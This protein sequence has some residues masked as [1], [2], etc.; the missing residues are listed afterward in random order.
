MKKILA[1]LL[2]LCLALGFSAC[3]GSEPDGWY[4]EGEITITKK[5]AQ[6]IINGEF[7]APENIIVIIGDGMGPNDITLAEKNVE[8]V[9]DFGL[10]LNQIK[11]HGLA[12]THSADNEITDSAASG[13]AL[14]TGVKTNNGYIG[15][16]TNGNDIK[17]MAEIAR[18]Q[19]KKI[20]II[21]DEDLSGATPTAF[22]VHNISRSNTAE[23][24][25]AMVKFKPDVMMSKDY[26]GVYAPLD[27]EARKIFSN[28]YLVAKDF[29]RFKEVLD[30]DPDCEKPFLGFLEG[31]STMPSNNLAQCAEVALKRL[32]NDNGFFLM[33]ESSGTDKFGHKNNMS[34]KLNSVVTL[35]RTV[36]AVLKFME[37]NP[38]TLL[39]ITSD[40]E[41]GGVKLPEGDE[42][43]K[44]LLTLTEHTA[45]PVRVFAVG[46][47][48]EYF[49]GKTVDNTDIAKFL[50]KAIKGE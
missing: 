50:I 31:F 18:E 45:T 39:L 28:E 12:T 35:D 16:D 26:M 13:T 34:G 6:K 40:H 22:A 1:L 23:L 49:S 30:T 33:I 4:T 36:A 41:T 10:V 24:V 11:N 19:G 3:S 47:G 46:E 8:G 20:G 29:R 42:D 5:Q 9:Y 27:S 37:K 48:S 2:S 17:N 32:K 21:T 15:K 43:L 44:D 25:N 14:S 38:D 7:T